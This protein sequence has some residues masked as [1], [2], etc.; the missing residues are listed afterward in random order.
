MSMKKMGTEWCRLHRDFFSFANKLR[1][2]QPTYSLLETV[3][4]DVTACLL[5]AFQVLRPVL[6]KIAKDF[7]VERILDAFSR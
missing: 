3:A 4:F 2:S 5:S 1:I 6:P 7:W